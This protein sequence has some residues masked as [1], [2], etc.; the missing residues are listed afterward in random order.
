MSYDGDLRGQDGACLLAW[1]IAICSAH[2]AR[3]SWR[4]PTACH[5]VNFRAR[6]ISRKD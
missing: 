4:R 5:I 1:M 2:V 6:A 3:A